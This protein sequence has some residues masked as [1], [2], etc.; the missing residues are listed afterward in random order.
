MVNQKESSKRS[1][2]S[3]RAAKFKKSNCEICG[4]TNRLAVHH[5][6]KDRHD[7]SHENIMTLCNS[8]HAKWH[9]EHGKIRG[10]DL[11][12]RKK[13]GYFRRYAKKAIAETGAS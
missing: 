7:N 1:T 2:L 11:K 9:W 10:K 13:D 8:C 6:N 12:P 5:I 3:D 4:G